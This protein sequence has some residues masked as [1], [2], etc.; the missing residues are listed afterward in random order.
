MSNRVNVYIHELAQIVTSRIWAKYFS[1]SISRVRFDSTQIF[2]SRN[3]IKS[4]SLELDS[5]APLTLTSNA[6]TLFELNISLPIA[7]PHLNEYYKSHQESNSIW[8]KYVNNKKKRG[9]PTVRSVTECTRI[10]ILSIIELND[11]CARNFRFSVWS[12][13][14]ILTDVVFFWTPKYKEK[15]HDS[16]IAIY[17]GILLL[18]VSK[19]II[20]CH[21]YLRFLSLFAWYARVNSAPK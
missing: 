9:L 4:D 3:W 12:F 15:H 21:F 10:S 8:L 13:V 14:M 18:K 20:R 16:K 17:I 2:I 6:L 1:S 7:V 5:S 19:Y 11:F